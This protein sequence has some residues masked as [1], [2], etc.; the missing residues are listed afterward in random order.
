MTIMRAPEA[1]TIFS[2]NSAPPPPLIRL[3]SRICL[4]SAV[5]HEIE[6][7]ERVE[8]FERNVQV[9]RL[10]RGALGR[11]RAGDVQPLPHAHRQKI[12]KG[13]GG[14]AGAEAELHAVPDIVERARRGSTFQFGGIGYRHEG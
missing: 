10:V 6:R 4:V 11:R 9:P 13:F 8:I 2:R 3:R 1:A 12:E 14:G 7:A 5:D